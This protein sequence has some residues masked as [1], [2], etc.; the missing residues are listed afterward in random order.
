VEEVEEVAE[1]VI[2]WRIGR[3]LA[4]THALADTIGPHVGTTRQ[5]TFRFG[6]ENKV[7]PEL[8]P[9]ECHIPRGCAPRVSR[10]L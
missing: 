10:E 4:D 8:E 5:M 6:P 7:E 1:G 2:N 3:L 9:L